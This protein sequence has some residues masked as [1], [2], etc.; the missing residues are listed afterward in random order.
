MD[1]EKLIYSD[2]FGGIQRLYGHS[3]LDVLNRSHVVVIGL[4]GVG[5]WTAE[6]LVRS[7]VGQISLIDLDDIC[8]TNT[9]RQLHT[10]STTIGQTKIEVMKERLL[11]INPKVKIDLIHDFVS[12]H[13]LEKII[14]NCD[15]IIDAIDSLKSKAALI[16]YA[17]KNKI[18]LI[19]TGASGGKQDPSQIRISDF[20]H[21]QGDALIFR[22]RKFLKRE[23]NYPKGKHTFNVDAIYS[24]ERV[25]FINESGEIQQKG[26]QGHA[27]LD[28]NSGLGSATFVT[29]SFGFFAS[30]MAVKRLLEKNE[31]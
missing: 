22:T 14:P 3:S 7:G 21:T 4:G 12:P 18:Q 13:N 24:A 9:N 23:Y 15:L 19:T 6:S 29:G 20:G 26:A 8:V 11:L 27:K 10:L 5:S 30:S 16:D 2:Q 1:E 17:I 25:K 31:L 28:C